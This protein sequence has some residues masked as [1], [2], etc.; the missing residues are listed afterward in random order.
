MARILKEYDFTSKRKTVHKYPWDKWFD[1][2]I[3]ELKQGEDFQRSV[4]NMYSLVYYT[5]RRND[6]N[7]QI[8]CNNANKSLIVQYLGK[9]FKR[10]VVRAKKNKGN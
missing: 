3:W 9:G 6:L 10:K 1:G 2:H 8:K 5:G 4:E 7:L